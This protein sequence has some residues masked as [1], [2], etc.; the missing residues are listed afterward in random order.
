MG[1]FWDGT[2]GALTGGAMTGL[3][4][5]GQNRRNRRAFRQQKKL[6]DLQMQNQMG[7]NQ[8]GHQLAMDMW[9]QT[10]YG[11]QVEHM[12]EAGLNPALMYG[13][14]GAGGQTGSGSG[15]SA[16]GGGAPAIQPMDMQNMLIGAQISKL[17]AET[18]NIE[19]DTS[20]KDYTIGNIIAS[21][22]DLK[23]KAKLSDAQRNIYR[24]EYE[25]GKD[26]YDNR[27]K[28]IGADLGNATIELD[29][30]KEQFDYLVQT[31]M[32]DAIKTANES[33]K[34]ATENKLTRKELNAFE[35]VLGLKIKEVN[36]QEFNA[37]TNK[38]NAWTN[39]LKVAIDKELGKEK[40]SNE[41]WSIGAS[42]LNNVLSGVFSLANQLPF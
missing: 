5:I 18:K 7:L 13:Q 38:M 25:F 41:R 15:G 31:S 24:L 26:S 19:K 6:M 28:Q 34:I 4:M 37:D 33:E 32:Y 14:A 39:E 30:M 16:A 12:K 40:L 3:S 11:A 17:N 8:Q 35:K 22:D 21:T 29:L 36:I 1:Q 27:L 20:V 23:A 42:I 9:N 10:N 2:G